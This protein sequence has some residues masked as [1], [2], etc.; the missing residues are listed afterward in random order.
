M[1]YT[2]RVSSLLSLPDRQIASLSALGS[3]VSES[4]HLET[5][6]S[7]D[8]SLRVITSAHVAPGACMCPQLISMSKLS[9]CVRTPVDLHSWAWA[10]AL[11]GMSDRHATAT[12]RCSRGGTERLSTL[13]VRHQAACMQHV[14]RHMTAG[15]ALLQ[16]AR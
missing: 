7:K 2:I 10:H 3:S 6:C 11:T 12:K 9:A 14:V 16:H 1:I 4:G 5:P 13:F 15:K 8:R